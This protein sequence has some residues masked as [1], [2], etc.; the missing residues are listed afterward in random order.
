[1]H[2]H[3]EC[4]IP[5]NN[6]CFTP[7]V[8]SAYGAL[9]VDGSVW[10]SFADVEGVT[11]VGH[12]LRVP[13]YG[14]LQDKMVSRLDWVQT[15]E[16]TYQPNI[17]LSS[18]NLFIGG[19]WREDFAW[20]RVRWWQD[21]SLVASSLVASLLGGEVTGY[22]YSR[23]QTMVSYLSSWSVNIFQGSDAG[24]NFCRFVLLMNRLKNSEDKYQ[25]K[26]G[27]MTE[28]DGPKK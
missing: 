13:S 2:S 16:Q 21:R 26:S 7:A 3:E 5:L 20:W 24:E 17:L 4:T 1:M 14:S 19:W 9:P 15:S 28:S 18:T 10:S 27:Q 6:G 25:R 23:I 11:S 8:F 22:Q 12:Q